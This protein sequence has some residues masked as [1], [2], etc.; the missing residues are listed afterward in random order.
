MPRIPEALIESIKRD[1]GCVA[2]LEARGLE[3][4]THGGGGDVVC[5][6]PF[7][8]DR[9]PSLIVSV[10]KNLWR[11]HGACGIGGDVIALIQKLNGVSFRH[12]VELAADGVP[13]LAASF[14]AC[15]AADAASGERKKLAR[16]SSARL[17][18]CP[19]DGSV[20]DARLM[21]QVVDFY[22]GRLVVPGNAGRAYLAER[23]LDDAELIRRFALGFAD[24]SLGLRLPNKQR[25]E[26]AEL[27]QRLERLGLFR[28]SGHEH[29]AGSVVVPIHGDDGSVSEMYGRKITA[30]LR[31]GTPLHSYLPGEHRGIWNA[32]P[33]LVNAGGAVVICEA[34]LDAMSCW[35]SGVRNVTAAYGVNGWTEDHWSALTSGKARDVFIAFDADAAGDVAAERLAEQLICRGF[36]AFRVHF[37]ADKDAN[38]VL[39]AKDG[40]RAAL[41]A[42]IHSAAWLGGSPRVVVPAMHE[43][44]SAA[45]EESAAEKIA[46]VAE[47]SSFAAAVPA[48]AA[49]ALPKGVSVRRDGAD[50]FATIGTRSY[51]VRGWNARRSGET[52]TVAL[53]VSVMTA[54]GE[55]QHH[56]RL[57]LYQT[58]QRVAFVSAAAEEC[59]LAV[60]VLKSDLGTL[61]LVAEAA[62]VAAANAAASTDAVKNPADAMTDVDKAAALELLCAADLP[63]RIV[64]DLTRCGLVGETVNKLVAYLA[65]S[66]RKLDSPVAVVVQSSTAAGKSTLM[67]RV[68][69][70]MPPEDVR[71]YSAISGKSPF[72]L[73][74]AN[75]KHRILAIAEE[76]GARKASYALKLL[77]SDGFLSMAATG[78]DP[79]SGKLVTHDYRV[80]GPV[81]LMLTTTAIDVDPELLNRCLVLTVDEEPAQTAAIQQAQREGRTLAGMH[82]KRERV[83]IEL[84]H[85][86]AQR[87]LRPLTV[88][89]PFATQLSFAASQTRLRRDH[90]KYL[91]MIDAVTFLF[92]HQRAVKTHRFDDGST[93]DYI[94]VTPAD[95]MLANRL[96]TAV[97]A[98]SLDDLP[99]QTRRFLIALHTWAAAAATAAGVTLERFSFSRRE[100]REGIDVG[101]T[102]AA[103]HLE[104]LAA[105]EF[106]VALRA[107]GDG[108]IPQYRLAWTPN[109]RGSGA[110]ALRGLG[111]VEPQTPTPTPTDTTASM[112]TMATCRDFGVP[113]GGVSDLPRQ[114]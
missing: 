50:L 59:G 74:T 31:S 80:E 85:R 89:N 111:L 54:Q 22:A 43:E 109:E 73:G 78:K 13:A 24:R 29:F 34:V 94:E 107:V 4:V 106:V 71:Q 49:S 12:A 20:D 68:L 53:R 67:D 72:Y 58:R 23:G 102:Q 75:L 5:R 33:G 64:N 39:T 14:A 79:E 57:D 42:L 97:L 65:A 7:H 95:I 30:G 9:T 3:F 104:R 16:H 113:V 37:P 27:R 47:L 51:R 52:L 81:M 46:A 21:Q 99:P 18:A 90:A 101:Q 66:S 55:R 108:A 56:D 61:I 83:A 28:S 60:E 70:L 103:L 2:V 19:L 25:K 69:A 41:A 93:M 110:A 44:K 100:A 36:T 48:V 76:E 112:C 98:R 114:A 1:V 10:S 11:C 62:E 84:L 38:A 45:K 35:L 92:Q 40:G 26:G 15:S 63:E 77:Q 17:L 105:H 86:N 88:V 96:A 6:C 8:D 87:L 32:G 91:A 82:A